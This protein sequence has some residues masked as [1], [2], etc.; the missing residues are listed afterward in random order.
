MLS[1][2]CILWSTGSLMRMWK[3][4]DYVEWGDPIPRD[5]LLLSPHTVQSVPPYLQFI[6]TQLCYSSLYFPRQIET[7]GL[8][9]N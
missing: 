1:A 5:N 8:E 4:R 2:R 9:R 7:L 6:V 3:A